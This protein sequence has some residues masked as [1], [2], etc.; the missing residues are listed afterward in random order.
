MKEKL[1]VIGWK[2][3]EFIGNELLKMKT[4]FCAERKRERAGMGKGKVVLTLPS[5][6]LC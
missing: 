1:T 4:F 3:F 2:H 6:L 5:G